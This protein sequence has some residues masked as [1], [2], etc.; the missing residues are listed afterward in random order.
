MDD[1]ISEFVDGK[2]EWWKNHDGT[3][4][5]R[6]SGLIK[7]AEALAKIA[8]CELSRD[9]AFKAARLKGEAW[10]IHKNA[11]LAELLGLDQEEEWEKVRRLLHES[12]RIVLHKAIGVEK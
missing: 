3:D 10:I 4:K 5:D 12:A 9:E 1:I 6:W 8:G 7:E 11:E 2:L